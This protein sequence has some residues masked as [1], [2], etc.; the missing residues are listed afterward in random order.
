M[1]RSR[2]VVPG[3][4]A[5]RRSRWVRSWPPHRPRRLLRSGSHGRPA[6]QAGVGLDVAQQVEGPT[7]HPRLPEGFVVDGRPAQLAHALELRLGQ[8]QAVGVG[9]VFIED[10]AVIESHAVLHDGSGD[11]L[12]AR[13]GA[14]GGELR[15]GLGVDVGAPGEHPAAVAAGPEADRERQ[16]TT[17]MGLLSWVTP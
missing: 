8:K 13:P 7:E 6:P 12:S 3:R 1:A 2:T 11:D 16:G 4:R 10:K 14:L 15:L 17:V 5:L 9:D